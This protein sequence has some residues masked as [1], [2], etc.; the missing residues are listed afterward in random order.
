MTGRA[1]DVGLPVDVGVVVGVP[2]AMVEEEPVVKGRPSR[3]EVRVANQDVEVE[4]PADA[5][6]QIVTEETATQ[7]TLRAVNA[8]GSPYLVPISESDP[9]GPKA[10]VAWVM[11]K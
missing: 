9:G 2:Q 1:A 7:I 11:S 4:A 5:G 3:F 10:G 6:I 8:D